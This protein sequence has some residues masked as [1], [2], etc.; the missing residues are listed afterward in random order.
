MHAFVLKN[1]VK[2][3]SC[4]LLVLKER[5]AKSTYEAQLNKN[6]LEQK[7]QSTETL[8]KLTMRRYKY[9]Q[10]VTLKRNGFYARW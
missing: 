5:L 4:F 10:S 1:C 3:M 2:N 8:A 9:V 7:K 6:V